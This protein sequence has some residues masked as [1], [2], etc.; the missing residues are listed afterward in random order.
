[1]RY[2]NSISHQVKPI[3][4][5]HDT[6]ALRYG[7]L[8]KVYD[9]IEQ[10]SDNTNIFSEE[11]AISSLGVGKNMLNAMRH[12][13]S[14]LGFIERNNRT[15]SFYNT[16]TTN[17][18]KKDSDEYLGII[19][20]NEFYHS[21]QF[22]DLNKGIDPYLESPTTLWLLHWALATNPNLITYY[23][24]FNINTKSEL[25]RDEFIRHLKEFLNKYPNIIAPSDSTLKKDVDCFIL[26]YSAKYRKDNDDVESNIESP[27]VE[28][29]LISRPSQTQI[30]ALRGKKS[31]L[32]LHTF[33]YCLIRFWQTFNSGSGSLSL[34][35]ATYDEC[36]VGRVFMFNEE[37]LI[38]YAEKL[39]TYH[40]PIV[41]TQ[42]AGIRQFQLIQGCTLDEVLKLS[43]QN[44]QQYDYAR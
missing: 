44:I 2:F 10:V 18:Q 19:P 23:W 43:I 20:N 42:S 30:R 40:Y 36:S 1:M 21:R 24:F 9:R 31:S 15:H 5:G 39:E 29:G 38:D 28:L 26:N 41:W 6:F 4:S 33:V 8:K 14:H 16:D 25:S 27:L 11:S 35:M 3:V 22:F 7:W 34:E 32:S 17:V 37:A 12:W 13:S